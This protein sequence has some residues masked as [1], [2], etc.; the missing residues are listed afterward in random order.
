MNR[1]WHVYI[2][3]YIYILRGVP[4]KER[5]LQAKRSPDAKNLV[6]FFS[7]LSSSRY[8]YISCHIRYD[9]AQIFVY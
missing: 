1:S 7:V 2:Y 6:Y 3:I 8:V 4:R 9:L 5:C